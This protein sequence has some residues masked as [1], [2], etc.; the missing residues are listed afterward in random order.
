MLYHAPGSLT[1]QPIVVEHQSSAP[2]VNQLP[3]H[4][5]GFF[6]SQ[7]LLDTDGLHGGEGLSPFQKALR[8]RRNLFSVED[9]EN[10]ATLS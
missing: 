1:H 6:L 8:D 10:S 9:I 7:H 2:L 4:F 5:A 3:G